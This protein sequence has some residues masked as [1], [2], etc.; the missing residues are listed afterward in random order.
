[1]SE[2]TV[3]VGTKLLKAYALAKAGK[4][5]SAALL[6]LEASASKDIDSLMNGLASSL[7]AIKASMEE[8]NLDD[9]SDEEY[10]DE[11]SDDEEE[12]D[13]YEE[14]EEDDEVSPDFSF[15]ETED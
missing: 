11:P 13:D 5:R 3:Q 6:F 9:I 7:I 1:M 2:K 4:K 8:E 15:L 12:L 10:E 14:V